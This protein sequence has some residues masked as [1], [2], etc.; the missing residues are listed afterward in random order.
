M[1]QHM[2]LAGIIPIA[3]FN[4]TFDMPYPWFMLPVDNGFSMIQKSVFECA[5]AGCQTIWIVAND[6]IAPI[7]KHHIGEWVYD[8]VY[9]YRKE[10]FYKDKRKEIP[11]YYVPVHPKDRDRRDSY[12]WSA[13]YGMH[14]AW[15]VS[16][17]LSKWIT[18]E[19]YYVSFPH[20]A[21][22]IYTL[23]EH[24]PMIN[25]HSNN[26]F[27]TSGG[28]TIKNNEYLSFTMFGED[29]K[30]CRRHVNSET[31]KTFYNTEVGEKY[32]SKKLPINERWSARS[33]DI[34]TVFSQVDETN[35]YR[36]DLEWFHSLENWDNYRNFMSSENFIQKPSDSLTKAHK[37]NI[38]CNEEGYINEQ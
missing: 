21:F 10:K 19:K 12:G 28:S 29:F 13:L 31:T 24:R 1:S 3:N 7:I 6:D 37:H 35:S 11:I 17:R 18:P 23:R 30:N 22:N 9:Y 34:E 36:H 8:P 15:Y 2:H 33:F 27:L 4:D 32:P 25:H 26:F 16:Q 38:I 14:S 20:A 5:I